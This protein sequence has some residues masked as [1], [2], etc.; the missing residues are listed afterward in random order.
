MAT[1]IQIKRSSGTTAPS[2]LAQGELAYT[3]GSGLQGNNGDRL[4]IGTGT[5]TDGVAANIDIIGGKYFTSLTDHV[6][7]TLTASSALLVD[8][9]K[10][11]DEIFI[12]NNASTGGQLKLN[13]GT[14]N[15][16]NY[17][18]LKAPNAVTT[19]T[20][21][22]LPDGDGS[23]GQFLKT[24]G[25]GNL[26]FGTV[27]ST[28]TLA[29]D[30]GANDTYTT[31]NTLTFTGGTGIDTTV[32]DD[33]ITIAVD[34][35]IATASSTT[36][37]TN[38]TFDA[39]GTGNSIS[40]I[41]VADFA[42]GVVDTDLSSVSASDDTLASAKAIKAYVDSQVTAQDLDF[43]ADTGGA[44]AI[45]LDSET[46]T[47]TGGTG[48]DTSGSG[49]TVTFAIDSTVTTNSGTQTLT[50]KTIDASSNTLSNIGNSSLTN[51]TISISDD[52]SSST[53]IPLGG[54]FSIL[55][56]TGITSSVSGSELTLDIDNT[57]V[58]TSGT[59]TLTNK[60]IDL[61]N[62]TLT[63]TT[64]EF[65]SALQDGSF[66]TLDGT[67]TLTNKTISSANNTIT[68]TE[69]NIS[70]LGSYIT[71]T[72][73]D[74]LQNKTIDSVN[75][76][77]TLDLSEGTLTGT[78][79]EFNTAVSDATLVSTTGTET[80]SNK[81]LT[82][83]KFADGGYIADA[84]GN[85]L[86]LLQTTTS[87]VNE[88]EI[89]NAAT[90]NAVQ[91]ATTGGDTNID[92][93]IS[94]KGSGV[95]DVDSSRI[96]NVTDPSGAQDAAT[97][98]YVD[99]VANGLDVKASVRVATTAALATSTYDNGAGT[100]TA[101]ANGALTID[102]V[103]VSAD[104][105]VLV[106][107]QASAVQNGLYKVTATG[108]AG[109]QWVL[110]RTPDGDEAVEITGGA[111]VF[112]EE[113]TANADNG[114][115]FTHNGTPT[116][117]S[118]NIT[119]A[120]FSGAGQI[121]AGDALTKTGNTLDVAVDD[122]TIEVSGDALQV[123][124]S[125]I[126]TN[127]LADTAVTEGKIA[128]NAVTAGKLATTLDLSSNTITLPSTFVTTTGTQTLTNKTINASQLV[129]SSVTNAK[130][131]NSTITLSGDSGSNAID[132]GDTLTVSGGEGIDTSQ[133]GDILTIAAELATTS[134]KGVA[135]FSADNFTVSTGVVTVT[136]I[137]GG[138]F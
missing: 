120:Q 113:G 132:L 64:A 135:S 101:D 49:N 114:Y 83:P 52:T 47:F 24:D 8:S 98:A 110:T 103:T 109:S 117:G 46:L 53:S 136:S 93:K 90:G 18:G 112:V 48:I 67:E 37:F 68:I 39:N 91:I 12:G 21:F 86:I 5:E 74:T 138:T 31:G 51:S 28:I 94:P 102:G 14:N 16:T 89:T 108:G 27:S 85:E 35:T 26:S 111:F 32:S 33:T 7:G 78:L 61:G 84:N 72:S 13:E 41:E 57:V 133:S 58:T 137:D 73:T 30:S 105:R 134:N 38:K 129:D 1:I 19:S 20:T 63:G 71:A 40:N 11:I 122:T 44:L 43:Q 100:I 45:D 66:A 79:A 23:N 128:N 3:Y 65:N 80:L 2:E 123:K 36:T 22:T 118:D 42:S 56:G 55:G 15:G 9:N 97:K 17:I 69:A 87:A 77:I 127:Q 95:V 106:K 125:G 34:A 60:T 54:G 75:N 131:A 82:A 116:L 6:P 104:D 88:L 119:V 50:N 126:G 81:T 92:L 130:L 76:T 10:A 121:S 70:D 62:N 115:V 29:A 99:S 124:A 96:T 4:F 59:Q 107:N 25:S